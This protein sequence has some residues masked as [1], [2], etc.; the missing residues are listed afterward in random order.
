VSGR[1]VEERRTS[2][3]YGQLAGPPIE[4][5]DVIYLDEVADDID[6]VTLHN[7][8]YFIY[9]GCVNLP[10]SKNAPKEDHPEGYPGVPEATCL[11][12]N[13]HKYQLPLLKDRC[14]FYLDQGI[15]PELA[16]ERLF[17]PECENYDALKNLYFDYI[18]L[19]YDKVKETREWERVFCNEDD[20]SLAAAKFR[21]RILFDISKKLSTLST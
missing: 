8:L 4:N 17:H 12:R 2:R 1:T 9:I 14:L 3:Q 21:A 6:F 18:V 7:V 5:R 15:T 20:I 13:A 19:N 16:V 11:F 10:F